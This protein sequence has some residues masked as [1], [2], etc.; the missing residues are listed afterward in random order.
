MCVDEQA[1]GPAAGQHLHSRG[2]WL[3]KLHGQKCVHSNLPYSHSAPVC[4]RDLWPDKLHGRKC[5][6]QLLCRPLTT[7]AAVQHVPLI[8]RVAPAPS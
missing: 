1:C 3:D 4:A 6:C 8:L 2:L 5:S 7:H